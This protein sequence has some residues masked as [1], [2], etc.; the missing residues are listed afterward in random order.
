MEI[1]LYYAPVIVI[2]RGQSSGFYF[3]FQYHGHSVKDSL[4]GDGLSTK[5]DQSRVEP[6]LLFKE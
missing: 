3:S 6:F 4:L 5:L 1:A 2:N